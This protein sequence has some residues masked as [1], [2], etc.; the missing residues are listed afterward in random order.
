MLNICSPSLLWV[1]S[2]LTLVTSGAVV[3]TILEIVECMVA[4]LVL[5]S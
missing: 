4:S 2:I 3:G 1:L 5:L